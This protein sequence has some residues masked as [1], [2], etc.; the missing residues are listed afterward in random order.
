MKRAIVTDFAMGCQPE[1][2]R[3]CFSQTCQSNAKQQLIEVVNNVK[4]IDAIPFEITSR[5][6]GVTR[7]VVRM[8]LFG[9]TEIC[10]YQHS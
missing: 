7:T 5:E 4:S 10:E 8:E 9:I 6:F 2:S 1:Y 3:S